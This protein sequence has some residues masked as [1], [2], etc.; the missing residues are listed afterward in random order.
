MNAIVIQHVKVGDLPEEWRTRLAATEDV[1]VTVRIE[2]E[3]STARPAIADERADDPMFGMWRD[4]EDL[5]DVAGY[6]RKIR[7]SRIARGA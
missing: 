3:S 2:E 5:A 1:R 4:R 7:A 6:V